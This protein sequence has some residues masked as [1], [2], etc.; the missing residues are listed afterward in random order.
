MVEQFT[1]REP[2]EVQA[3]REAWNRIRRAAATRKLKR[4]GR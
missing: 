2:A 1:S 3:E 4:T